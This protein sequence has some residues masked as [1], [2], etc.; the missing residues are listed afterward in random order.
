MV[1]IQVAVLPK[2]TAEKW[3]RR[4]SIRPKSDVSRWCVSYIPQF[5]SEFAEGRVV[6]AETTFLLPDAATIGTMPKLGT[7]VYGN[8][9]HHE[10][11]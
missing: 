5:G 8:R 2:S 3:F 6:S 11:P 4:D 1:H 10:K 9:T 7:G